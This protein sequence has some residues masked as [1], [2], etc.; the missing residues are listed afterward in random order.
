LQ[1]IRGDVRDPDAVRAALDGVE[2]VYHFAAQVAVT[3]SLVGPR[4][5]FDVNAS[6]TLNLLEEIRASARQPSL[7]YSSTNKV[8]GGLPD[9]AVAPIGA[10]YVPVEERTRLFGISADRPLDFHSP[11]GCSKGAADQYVIDYSRSFGLRTVVMRMSCIYGPHQH[12]NED[13]GWV[14][15]FA[16]CALFGSPVTVYGDGK[17]VRDV[18]YVEDLVDAFELARENMNRLSGRAFNIGGGTD[19]TLSVLELVEHLERITGRSLHVS[20]DKWRVGDQRY[21]VSDTSSFRAATGWRPRVS[22]ADGLRAL[23]KWFSGSSSHGGIPTTSFSKPLS[24]A[25]ARP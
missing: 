13:Q 18:L 19:N 5:D 6:G 2:H 11:Y 16:R 12:G 25:G 22:V 9:I 20:M 24:V 17:Q 7:V 23:C 21:Y 15:H 14:A 4:S 3:T 8:Y 10:R 1:F